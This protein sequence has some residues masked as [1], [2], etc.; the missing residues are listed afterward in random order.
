MELSR[1]PS[2]LVI[3]PSLTLRTIIQT[4]LRRHGYP[5]PSL[6]ADPIAALQALSQ[7][8]VPIP[9]V[10]LVCRKLPHLD[11]LDVIRVMRRRR[12]PIAIA[13]LLS[14]QDGTLARIQARLAGAQA[15]LKKPFTVQQ[16]LQILE[17]LSPPRSRT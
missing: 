10:A 1:P 2:L 8:R 17:A 6:F 14:E 11:G 3:E 16:L 4:A 13:L 15:T 7:G 5:V 9:D 12:Y